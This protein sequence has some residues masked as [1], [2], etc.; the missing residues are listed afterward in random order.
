MQGN[1]IKLPG[2]RDSNPGTRWT[3]A[4]EGPAARGHGP[5]AS[6]LLFPDF[7]HVPDFQHGAALNRDRTMEYQIEIQWAWSEVSVYAG[8]AGR[9][10]F[11]SQG[12]SVPWHSPERP[13]DNPAEVPISRDI[14]QETCY[15]VSLDAFSAI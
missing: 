4:R 2:N 13:W 10:P 5:R 11:V 15:I 9:G 3:Q 6:T 7:Q 1:R 12:L 14:H 8:V